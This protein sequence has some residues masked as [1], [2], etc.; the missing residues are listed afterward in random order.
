MNYFKAF[1]LCFLCLTCIVNAKEL[2][3]IEIHNTNDFLSLTKK[4][5]EENTGFN[6]SLF[7]D[8]NLSSVWDSPIGLQQDGTCMPFSG[9]FHGNNHTIE[10]L[11]MNSLESDVFKNAGLF[12]N[13]GLALVDHLV[14][15]ETCNFT[16]STV[17]SLSVWTFGNLTVHGVVNKASVNG[18]NDVGGFLGYCLVNNGAV[19]FED[20]INEGAVNA[21]QTCGSGFIGRFSSSH[22]SDLSIK[23]CINAGNVTCV[24]G[25][26][27]GSFGG[28]IGASNDNTDMELVFVDVINKGVISAT[29]PSIGGMIGLAQTNTNYNITVVNATNDGKIDSKSLSGGVGGFF[30]GFFKN[31]N[32]VLTLDDSINNEEV[33]SKQAN[34]GGFASFIRDCVNMTATFSKC[35]NNGNVTSDGGNYGRY[36]GGFTGRVDGNDNLVL[37]YDSCVNNGQI[38]SIGTSLGGLIGEVNYGEGKGMHVTINNCTNNGLILGEQAQLGGFVGYGVPGTKVEL[39]V[40]NS[41][42]NGRVENK[43]GF[44]SGLVGMVMFLRSSGPIFL[45]IENSIN[46][47]DVISETDSSCGFYCV[48]SYPSFSENVFGTVI[49]SHNRGNITGCKVSGITNNIIKAHNVVNTG[50]VVG[51]KGSFSLWEVFANVSKAYALEDGCVSCDNATLLTCGSDGV[52]YQVNT[53]IR[54]DDLLNAEVIAQGRSVMWTGGLDLTGQI[55]VTVGIPLSSTLLLAQGDTWRHISSLY[56]ETIG[57]AVAVYSKNKTK[58]D[59]DMGIE[60]DINV[61]LLYAVTAKGILSETWLQ[62]YGTSLW[63][64][65]ALRPFFDQVYAIVND[66]DKTFCNKDTVITN[67]MLINVYRKPRVVIDIPKTDRDTISSSEVAD[68]ISKISGV[69]KERFIVVI[70][71]DE[72]MVTRIVVLAEDEQIALDIA[73]AI[74]AIEKGKT[75]TV[76]ILCKYKR[77]FVVEDMSVASRRT[78][79]HAV[80]L[81]FT[82]IVL[83][84]VSTA[85]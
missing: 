34:V 48:H 17:G 74:N 53:N 25:G 5:L 30:G 28:F 1:L 11:V 23:R 18:M 15:G 54:A 35:T 33:L 4:V 9:E 72:Q 79:I 43:K 70:P 73:N 51:T 83:A 47:G 49:N 22:E 32:M 39:I 85:F 44:N 45:H 60:T 80:A 16:G 84:T 81:T 78:I 82:W 64:I 20:C 10:G 7:T 31:I 42:N 40:N 52:Y 19:I 56:K 68:V 65:E 59:V 6:V 21:N 12:C 77:C 27:G 3:S 24:N 29:V 69:S 2:S 36:L 63:D 61:T 57:D 62:G 13:I 8:L 14:I 55:Q 71:D 50:H 38:H 37:L 75:C 41:V 26:V 67:R 58:L 46:N 76:G 66:E